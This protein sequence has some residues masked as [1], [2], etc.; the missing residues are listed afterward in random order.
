MNVHVFSA[1][2]SPSIANYAL[3]KTAH[4]NSCDFSKGTVNAVEKDFYMDDLLKPVPDDD[5][6][7]QLASELMVLLQRGGFRLTKLISSSKKVLATIPASER[8]DPL[9]LSI[10][11]L[12]IL[13]ALGI[14]WNVEKMFSNS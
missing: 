10:D 14:Q 12:P 8:A 2:D 5:D 6:V 3:K 4:D 13:R 9:N 7:I 11:K 1:K